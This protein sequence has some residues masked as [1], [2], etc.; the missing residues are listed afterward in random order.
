[1]ISKKEAKESKASISQYIEKKKQIDKVIGS[2][3]MYLCSLIIYLCAIL[4]MLYLS[5]GEYSNKL[6][7]LNNN[8]R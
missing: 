7:V 4:W 1:M 3:Y 5:A 8:D 6:S 2:K